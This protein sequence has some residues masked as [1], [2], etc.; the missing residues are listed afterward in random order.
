MLAQRALSPAAVAAGEHQV[1]VVV[2]AG[3]LADERIDSPAA[4][5]NETNIGSPQALEH[6]QHVGGIH[7]CL[8]SPRPMA[9]GD[10]KWAP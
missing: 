4:I 3:L 2:G 1:Q 8:L 10:L 7:H 6:L 5:E 9:S